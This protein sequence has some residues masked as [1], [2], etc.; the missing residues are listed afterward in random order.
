[1]YVIEASGLS[2]RFG[3]I[4][5]VDGLDLEVEEGEVF[6]LLG[7]NGAGK[8]TTIRILTGQT[9][10]NSGRTLIFGFDVAREPA[11]AKRRIGL[12][13]EVSNI[14]DELSAFDNLVFAAQLYG[15][16]R[17]ERGERARRLFDQVGLSE[18]AGDRAGSF[19]RGMKRRLTIAA[20]L[21][22]EP[23]LLVMDEPTTGLDVQSARV[24][25]RLVEELNR[26]GTTVLLTTH[27]IEEADQLCRRVA[28]MNEGKITACDTPEGLKAALDERHAVEVSFAP[29]A[30]LE[31][32]LGRLAGII[33]VTR[34]GGKYR[35]YVEAV[36]ECVESI[37]AFARDNGLRIVSLDTLRPSLEDAFVRLTG[38]SPEALAAEKEARKRGGDEG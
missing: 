5:A 33:G 16:P 8:T 15:V 7:P 3:G 31:A 9:T 30:D 26:H 18:R 36:S 34:I 14:Y 12:V 29:S 13:P 20:A 19:S 28:I 25:R 22:H 37:V 24:V 32:K 2:K 4:E 35:L 27:Y 38:L 6:G 21:I 23:G 17:G 10:P 1:M 11:A